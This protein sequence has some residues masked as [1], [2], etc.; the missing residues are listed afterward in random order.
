MNKG[1]KKF[2]LLEEYV[3]HCATDLNLP[4]NHLTKDEQILYIMYQDRKFTIKTISLLLDKSE[5]I[6][7][8]ELLN[9]LEKNNKIDLSRLNFNIEKYNNIMNILLDTCNGIKIENSRKTLVLVK[10]R[11]KYNNIYVENLDIQIA[12]SI[13]LTK[14]V[15]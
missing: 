3:K 9:L 13:H 5:K 12:V 6:I 7:Q 8:S 10:N 1:N 4:I 2:N 14:D 11:L 15:N